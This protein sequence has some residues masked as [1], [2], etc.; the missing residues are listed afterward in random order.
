MNKN[1]FNRRM[2]NSNVLESTREVIKGLRTLVNNDV[3]MT[4]TRHLD[5]IKKTNPKIND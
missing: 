4:F 1:T 5:S 3:S 2:M